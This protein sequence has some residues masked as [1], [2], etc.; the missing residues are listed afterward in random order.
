MTGTPDAQFLGMKFEGA[1]GY[2]V[3]ITRS[4]DEPGRWRLSRFDSLGP[5][6]HTT[7]DT[8]RECLQEVRYYGVRLVKTYFTGMEL[9]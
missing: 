3:A 9:D 5:T 6:G 2:W 4:P 1:N 8:P 7:R